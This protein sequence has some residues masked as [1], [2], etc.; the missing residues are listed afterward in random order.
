MQYKEII[1]GFRRIADRMDFCLVEEYA[2]LF[3][4]GR[5]LMD[6]IDQIVL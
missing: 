1:A 5:H 6:M 3:S 2:D 4:N